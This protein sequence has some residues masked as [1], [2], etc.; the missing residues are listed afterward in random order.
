MK[1]QQFNEA[2]NQ[3]L[4][5]DDNGTVYFQSYSTIICKRE[6]NG[7]IILDTRWDNSATTNKYRCQF[8]GENKPQT[9]AKIKSGDYKI[10]DLNQ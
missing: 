10:E 2:K 3:F 7:L 1:T 8:L 5:T 6:T 4:L 9:L